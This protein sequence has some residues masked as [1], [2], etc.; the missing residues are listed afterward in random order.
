MITGAPDDMP[1]TIP[2]AEP[3][4]ACAGLLLLHVPPVTISLCVIVDPTQTL[5]RPVIGAGVALTVSIAVLM[6]PAGVI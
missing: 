3:T 2:E 1:V 4:V 5:L 6:Q